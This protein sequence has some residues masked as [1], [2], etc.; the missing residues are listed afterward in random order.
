MYSSRVRR[1]VAPAVVLLCAGCQVYTP[2][3]LSSQVAKDDIRLTLTDQGAVDLAKALGVGATQLEGHIDAV[4]DST[5]VL[6]ITE[7][8]R[9]SGSD[10]KWSGEPVPIPRGDVATVERRTTSVARSL[11]L[12]GA[13]AAGAILAGTVAGSVEGGSGTGQQGSVK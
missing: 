11:V 8:T 7:L 2:I 13:I 10:E 6:R 4:T 5:I 1:A 3:S 9:L 12:G